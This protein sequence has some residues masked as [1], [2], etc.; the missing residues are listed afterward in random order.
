M[1]YLVQNIELLVSLL[2][3]YSL[4]LPFG[5]LRHSY[6]KLSLK[7]FLA[8]H[9]PVP[10]IICLRLVFDIELTLIPVFIAI[11]FLGQYS[12][13]KIHSWYATKTFN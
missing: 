4:N 12:G 7:W 5:F 8:I 6:Q 13:G 2:V 10:V 9:I 3:T 1:T 11:F